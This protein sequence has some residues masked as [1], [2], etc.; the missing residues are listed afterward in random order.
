[1]QELAWRL[2]SYA[3]EL[4]A[5]QMRRHCS[6]SRRHFA[7]LKNATHFLLLLLLFL[8]LLFGKYD[9]HTHTIK[10][11]RKK[12]KEER[13]K[14]KEE[15]SLINSLT[16]SLIKDNFPLFVSTLWGCP[17]PCVSPPPG[18][19][20]LPPSLLPLLPPSPPLLEIN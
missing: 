12:K 20:P 11:K 3:N 13:R 18:P 5:M 16:L 6:P 8:L 9:T 1:M 15:E 17:G 19:P 2:A 10:K 14:K 7:S 4:A